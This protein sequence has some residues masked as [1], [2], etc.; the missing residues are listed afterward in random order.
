MKKELQV[1]EGLVHALLIEN[2]R[3]NADCKTL[4]EVFLGVAE[5]TLPADQYRVLGH[6]YYTAL[7]ENTQKAIRGLDAH[8]I[9]Q[10]WL[11]RAEHDAA[12]AIQHALSRFDTA[13]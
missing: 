2:A 8:Q 6:N 1:L 10:A 4:R 7:L 11:L 12:S 9:E 13:S 3:L 5:E